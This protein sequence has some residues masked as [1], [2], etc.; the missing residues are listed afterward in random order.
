M[1]S[2]DAALR[3]QYD[4]Q[5]QASKDHA[6]EN[7]K[8]RRQRHQFSEQARQ[9][10]EKNRDVNGYH[11]VMFRFHLTQKPYVDIVEEHNL[12]KISKTLKLKSIFGDSPTNYLAPVDLIS[13]KVTTKFRRKY[14]FL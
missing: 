5:N 6:P 1:Q 8:R 9:T 4:G 14:S 13:R 12:T 3:K 2:R 10:E 11:A 7:D